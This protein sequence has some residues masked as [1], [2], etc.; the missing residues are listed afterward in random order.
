MP[1]AKFNRTDTPYV[2]PPAV[3]AE[4]ERIAPQTAAPAP[5]AA[6]GGV[7]PVTDTVDVKLN[8]GMVIVLKDPGVACQ[9][10]VYRIL[11]GFMPGR[12][13]YPRGL[14]ATIKALMYIKSINGNPVV[15]AFDH[16]Q[17]QAVMNQIG[18][19]GMETVATAYVQTFILGLD[20]LPL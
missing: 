10:M 2:P 6:P 7:A 17:A 9:P 14:V 15:R 13:S 1:E 18:D 8:N 3:P 12:D 11:D 20:A 4:R 19:A 16:V 5:A